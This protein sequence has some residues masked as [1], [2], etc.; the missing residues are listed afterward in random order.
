MT[1]NA[2]V[3]KSKTPSAIRI[4]KGLSIYRVAN[5]RKWYV[6]VWDRR[7]KSYF[8]KSTGQDSAILAQDLAQE[9]ALA[10][11]RA[12]KPV[13]KEFTFRSFAL[14]LLHRSRLQDQTGERS[15]G[16]VKALHW[17]IQNED[18]GLLRHFGERDVR[19]IRTHSFQEYMAD[20]TKRRPDLAAS[21]RNT[22]M[23][24]FRNVMK[25]A[26]D[27]GAIEAV[28]QTPR[29]KLKDNPRPF[30]RFHPLVDKAD[31]NYQKLLRTVRKM[32]A[33]GVSVRGL[34]VTDEMYD[35]IL[36]LTHSFVRP[37]SSELYTIRHSDVTV[38]EDPRRLIVTVRDG[39]TGFR[40]ANT[41]EAAVSVYE[42]INK[43][44][45]NAKSEDYIFLPQ[46]E[47]RT[48]ASTMMQRLF[49][50]VLKYGGLEVDVPTGK[51]HTLY[52][53]RHTAICMRIINSGG[54]VNIFNL[55]K[56]AGTSVEQIERFYARFLPLSKEMAK[57][58]QLFGD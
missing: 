49:G 16:Y 45:P 5:S 2:R 8:V 28:P 1:T 50:E 52:S 54:K 23:A 20:L 29:V 22:I 9:L 13:E 42:R 48:T 40:A 10:M 11:L 46:Y 44:Y 41:M 3:G 27:E 6:R 26:R 37:I 15:A 31:D 4:Y 39:K 33:E 25:I 58:L 21:T 30:F 18:W 7:T 53:L 38:A 24:A 32:T 17:S 12:E 47:N 14:K 55:A 36:F 34:M 19:H 57:N 56:N 43:R 35:L 51:K